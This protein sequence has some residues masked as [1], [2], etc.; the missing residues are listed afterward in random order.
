MMT[1]KQRLFSRTG[2]DILPNMKY[3]GIDYGTKRIGVAISDQSGMIAFPKEIFSTGEQALRELVELILSEDVQKIIIGKSLDLKGDRNAIM[4]D[5]DA[6]VEELYKLTQVPI[7]LEDERFSS[8]AVRAFDWTKP[9]ATP[10][11]S[12]KKNDPIDDRA[13]AIML[14]RY[15]D[16]QT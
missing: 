13:A 12:D 7:E 3:L 5:I 4:E 11:R 9:I 16:K 15:L 14:Q 1:I 8:S 6:F 2:C 10:R